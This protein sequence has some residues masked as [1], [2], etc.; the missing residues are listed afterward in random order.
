VH[1][2]AGLPSF[3]E[4][5]ELASNSLGA[6][7]SP[8]GFLWGGIRRMILA[9]Q[10]RHAEPSCTPQKCPETHYFR[11]FARQEA[12]RNRDNQVVSTLSAGDGSSEAQHHRIAVFVGPVDTIPIDWNSS[13]GRGVT[14][15]I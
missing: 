3:A 8:W 6:A 5:V 7:T 13:R 1:D 12:K 14:D 4:V 10:A 15:A 9:C 2:R 11:D